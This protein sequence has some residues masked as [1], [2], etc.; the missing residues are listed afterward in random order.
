MNGEVHGNILVS[1]F[2]LFL[3]FSCISV[4]ITCGRRAYYMYVLIKL[5]SS[6]QYDRHVSTLIPAVFDLRTYMYA[7]M[8]RV[9]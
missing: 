2:W 3:V 8:P 4:S 5:A 9:K 6:N 7:F 1:F